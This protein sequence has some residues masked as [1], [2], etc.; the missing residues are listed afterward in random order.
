MSLSLAY[1]TLA[2]AIVAEVSGSTLL[3][4]S[5]GF[6]RLAPTLGMVALYVVSFY[7]LALTLRV[8]PLGV[9]YAI[10]AGLGIVLTAA[11]GAVLLGQRLDLPAIA[12]IAMIVGGVLVMNLFS[13]S[14]G[15]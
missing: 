8:I 12:G 3:Q 9:A 2:L 6:T 14:T 11:I 13:G 10:W 5:D 1:G 7:L 15:H 4:K